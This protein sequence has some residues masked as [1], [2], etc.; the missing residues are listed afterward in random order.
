M[1]SLDGRNL[2]LDKPNP[3]RMYDYALGGD[4]NFEIDRQALDKLLEINPDAIAIARTNRAFLRRA[5]EFLL[6]QGIDQFLDIGSGIPTVANVHEVAHRT[7]PQARVVYVDIDPIAIAHSRDILKNEPHATAIQGDARR[8]NDILAHPEVQRLLDFS[9]PIGLLLVTVLHYITDD[10][11]AEAAVQAFRA[12]LASGSFMV[13]SHYTYENVPADIVA[14]NEHLMKTTTNPVI[15]RSRAEIARFFD[16]LELLDPGL[17]Y[18][19]QWR[20]DVHPVPNTPPGPLELE[21]ERS[22]V[23]GGVARIP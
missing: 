2:D 7:N 12:P 20:P 21:P 18:L 4:H 16:N 15:G 17:V 10:A 13:V 11:Q 14:R 19:P 9:R 1:D 5:V 22:T 8:P 3:S 6:A 23:L